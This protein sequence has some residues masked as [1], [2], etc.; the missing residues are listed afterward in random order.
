MGYLRAIFAGAAICLAQPVFAFDTG[1]HIDATW[2]AGDHQGFSS[3]A[4]R[5]MQVANWLVN[6]YSEKNP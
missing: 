5:L 1:H 2:R 4:R 3:D 6:Y